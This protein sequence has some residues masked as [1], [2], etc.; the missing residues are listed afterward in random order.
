MINPNEGADKDTM[1][2]VA[3]STR[4]STDNLAKNGDGSFSSLAIYIFNKEDGYCEYS[5]LIPNFDNQEALE[6]FSRSINVSSKTKMIYAIANYINRPLL[7]SKLEK[8]TSMSV[9][10]NLTIIDVPVLGNNILMVGKREV[11]MNETL[12]DVEIPMEKL[13]AR[14]DIY[15]F[16]SSDLRDK[17]VTI[18]K[19]EFDNQVTNSNV[20]YQNYTMMPQVTYGN[21]FIDFSPTVELNEIPSDLGEIVPSNATI[22]YYSYQNIVPSEVLDS[23]KSSSLLFTVRMDGADY[24]YRGY[25]T[26]NGQTVNKYS[27]M[28]NTVYTIIAMLDHPDNYLMLNTVALPWTISSSQIG[29]AVNDSDYELQPLNGNDAGAS[30]GFVSFPYMQD[31]VLRNETSYAS[32]NF[33]LTAPVGA[34]W[35]ATITNGLEF[36]FGSTGSTPGRLAVSKGI[37]GDYS[38]EIKVGATKSWNGEERNTYMYITVDGT[39]LKINPLQEDGSRKFPGSNDTDILITQKEYQ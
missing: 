34:V 32:Y 12:V 39:K 26:D 16:K 4:A 23:L 20:Q 28:R 35:T 9:L 22:S 1:L 24:K 8:S 6:S 33:R 17:T 27:L 30:G 19:I 29:H 38:Y 10:D 14:L 37:A 25:I 13:V 31:N 21:P 3:I 7:S 18:E 2:K 15:A 11:V 5:E 36:A